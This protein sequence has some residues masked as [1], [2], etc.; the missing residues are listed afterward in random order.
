LLADMFAA[1]RGVS[2]FFVGAGGRNSGRPKATVHSN[3]A[4]MRLRDA[5]QP[6][7]LLLCG[8]IYESSSQWA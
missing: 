2:Y 7:I 6:G 3:F 8:R 4:W 1:C 5:G